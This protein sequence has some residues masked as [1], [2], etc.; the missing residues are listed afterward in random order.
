MQ[1]HPTFACTGVLFVVD[2]AGLCATE[3]WLCA[4]GL[5]AMVC[6][7]CA[8]CASGNGFGAEDGLAVAEAMKS[9]KQLTSVDLRGMCIVCGV[10]V[11]CGAMCE[12]CECVLVQLWPVATVFGGCGVCDDTMLVWGVIVAVCALCV[13]CISQQVG[14]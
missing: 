2:A 11:L 9:C 7:V 14:T 6:A 5:V 4:V 13:V 1:I 10:P 8:V 12:A 3:T